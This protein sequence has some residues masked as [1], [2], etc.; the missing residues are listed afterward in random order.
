MP[1]SFFEN[2]EHLYPKFE[3]LGFVSTGK[4]NSLSFGGKNRQTQI[5]KATTV[6]MYFKKGRSTRLSSLR[7]MLLAWQSP[8]PGQRLNCVTFYSHL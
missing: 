5:L 6:G 3:Y 7:E 1:S 4:N 2:M 8:D